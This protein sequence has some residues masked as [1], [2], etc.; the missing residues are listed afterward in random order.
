MLIRTACAD[1]AKALERRL[2]GRPKRNDRTPLGRKIN[3]IDCPTS[4]LN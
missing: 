2:C 3:T 4:R 1:S